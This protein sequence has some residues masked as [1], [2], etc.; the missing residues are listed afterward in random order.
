MDVRTFGIEEELLLVDPHSGLPS[1]VA[2]AV[3][4]GASQGGGRL[5]SELQR[6]QVEVSTP[7]CTTLSDLSTQVRLWRGRAAE[8]A[9][10]GGAAVAALA[11]SPLPAESAL[12]S[13]AR[14]DR[15]AREYG[16]TVAELL[17]CGCHVHVSVV[18]P[19]EGV[20]VIDRIRPWL[21]ALLALSG[22]S[23][24]WQGVDTGYASYRW[25]VWSRWPSAGPTGLFGSADAYRSAIRGMLRT[26]AIVDE[27]MIYFDAR[28]SRTYP[29]VELRITDVCLL[30]DDAVLVAALCRA[31]VE[32]AAREWQEGR[33]A[34]PVRL[35]ELRLATWRAARAG[36]HD[37]LV[38]P[39]TGRPAPFDV[40]VHALFEHIETALA[41]ATDLN[42]AEELL[43]RLLKRGNGADLQRATLHETTTLHSV[44][45]TAVSLTL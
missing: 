10:A 40:V 28:L 19:E 14:Y 6:T 8:A 30:A 25:Q 31:L 44:V 26:G 33:P 7:P 20:A 11:T 32:T 29:T 9:R 18:T 35:E 37:E 42:A 38:H 41:D 4:L 21:P 1:P 15:I 17:T 22:N 43:R 24:F 34:D 12:T 36:L 13:S 3:L 27:G 16:L 23:P 45:T 39:R 5:E 2:E